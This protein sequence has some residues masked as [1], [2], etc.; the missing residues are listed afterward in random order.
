MGIVERITNST[1]ASILSFSCWINSKQ[2]VTKYLLKGEHNYIST[3]YI[4]EKEY[5]D[6]EHLLIRYPNY[7]FQNG[8]VSGAWPK[9]GRRGESFFLLISRA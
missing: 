1:L 8:V 7:D 2:Y 6:N 4:Y 9:S 5:S 3:V